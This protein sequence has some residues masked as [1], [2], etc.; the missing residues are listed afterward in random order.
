M[1]NILELDIVCENDS[2]SKCTDTYEVSYTNTDMQYKDFFTRYLY[3]NRPCVVRG[4]VTENWKSASEWVTDSRPN[5]AY[6]CRKFGM[7]L[8]LPVI[9]NSDH[10]P[11]LTLLLIHYNNY[12]IFLYNLE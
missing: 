10:A 4:P 5:F 12:I 11:T 6:I 3:G 9:H 8:H 7:V 2:H 1:S